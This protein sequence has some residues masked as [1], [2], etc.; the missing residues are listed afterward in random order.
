MAAERRFRQSFLKTAEKS[1]SHGH[2]TSRL[3]YFLPSTPR[4]VK[5]STGPLLNLGMDEDIV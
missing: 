4:R 5:P 2:L 3:D 1:I